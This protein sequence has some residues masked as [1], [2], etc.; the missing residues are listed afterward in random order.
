MSWFTD[1]RSRIY[2]ACLTRASEGTL[3]PEVEGVCRATASS[4]GT[5]ATAQ[6][7]NAV[8]TGYEIKQVRETSQKVRNDFIRFRDS[9]KPSW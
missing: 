4:L 6:Y 3:T 2:G 5:Q 8:A 1:I 7:D 9:Y